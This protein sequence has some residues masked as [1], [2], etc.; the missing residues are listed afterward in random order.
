ME[1]S[2]SDER[3][4]QE[5][6]ETE[7]G[8]LGEPGTS[9]GSTRSTAVPRRR[10]KQSE[11]WTENYFCMD[12]KQPQLEG[13]YT[14]LGIQEFGGGGTL[15]WLNKDRAN[16]RGDGIRV[17]KKRC[18]FYHQTGCPFV[19]RELFDTK[20]KLAA[21]EIGAIPHTDH[22]VQK[23]K[24]AT[25]Q[26]PGVHKFVQ[27]M[28]ISSPSKLKQPPSKIVAEA[29]RKGIAV[30]DSTERRIKRKLSRLRSNGLSEGQP[31][32]W[33]GIQV[34]CDSFKKENI[35][36]FNEHSVYLLGLRCDAASETLVAVLSTENLLLNAYRQQFWGNPIFFAA[37]ASYRL[38]QEK[39]GVYPVITT[40]LAQQ[41]KTI[42]YG[43]ISS[44]NHQAQ[45]IIYSSIKKELELIVNSRK[46]T[47]K[48][49]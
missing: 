39:Y 3:E 41:T 43:I 11:I 38:T 6:E 42:A 37:D 4:W 1:D 25:Q 23:Q 7:G 45:T 31:R 10:L 35:A 46:A 14:T 12:I 15:Q 18:T 20:T 24:V 17:T 19:I 44:E 33:G 9:V 22:N 28:L 32:N 30:T 21:I 47:G 5:E 16:T 29:R 40:N 27:G 13:M 49:I 8:H 2:S 34:V 48:P 26:R 36:E